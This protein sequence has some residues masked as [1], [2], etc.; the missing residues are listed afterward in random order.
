MCVGLLS[1]TIT[2]AVS[3]ATMTCGKQGGRDKIRPL[4]AHPKSAPSKLPHAEDGGG[5]V[6]PEIE[7]E[8][9]GGVEAEVGD[10]AADEL[11]GI[12]AGNL[13]RSDRLVAVRADAV[14]DCDECP[15]VRAH[16]AWIHQHHHTMYGGRTRQSGRSLVQSEFS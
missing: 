7:Q 9:D 2:K 5:D 6:E 12:V 15:A 3:T 11:G 14:F 1:S 10:E 16:A 8:D 13:A 4:P